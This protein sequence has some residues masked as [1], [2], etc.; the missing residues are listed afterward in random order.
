VARRRLRGVAKGDEEGGARLFIA[1]LG[2]EN[3]LG[4]EARA[5]DRTE[6]KP[7]VREDEIEPEVGDDMWARDVSKGRKRPAYPFGCVRC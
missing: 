5:R 4:F 7:T 1:A 6:G 2:V 3:R